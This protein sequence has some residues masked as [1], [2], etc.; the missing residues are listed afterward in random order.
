MAF[1]VIIKRMIYFLPTNYI[2]NLKR[3]KS[4]RPHLITLEQ[5]GI[6]S[7]RDPSESNRFVTWVNCS[8]PSYKYIKMYHSINNSKL[9][10]PQ[11]LQCYL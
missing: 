11:S 9:M 7:N 1:Y 5:N 8:G 10:K 6:K 2:A 4:N 3:K